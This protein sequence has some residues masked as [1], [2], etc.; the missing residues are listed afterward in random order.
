M[1]NIKLRKL[2]TKWRLYEK[3]SIFWV[4]ICY[5][6][7]YIIKLE[8]YFRPDERDKLYD[9]IFNLF[10]EYEYDGHPLSARQIALL[11][12]VHHSKI[13]TILAKAKIQI[14]N[15]IE[16]QYSAKNQNLSIL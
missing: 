12:W 11:L 14:K 5:D 9:M 4:T 7:D 6:Q 8:R 10:F 1:L 15:E 13:D 3:E 16:K 2:F